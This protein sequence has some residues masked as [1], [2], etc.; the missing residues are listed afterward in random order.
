[1]IV[2]PGEQVGVEEEFAP[3]DFVYLHDGRLLASL[4]GILRVDK[5]G[6]TVSVIP[7]RER[8]LPSRGD[9]VVCTVVA[10]A[11]VRVGVLRCFAL[12]RSGKFKVIKP[13]TALL[14]VHQIGDYGISVIHEAVGIGDYVLA[15]VVSSRGPPYTIS[16]RGL[17]YG[18]IYSICP[19]CRRVLSRRGSS[20]HC[21]HCGLQVRRKVSINYLI[22]Q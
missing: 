14:P 22:G 15:K 5:R 16:T 1:V 19:N 3:L 20:L 8:L 12:S 7:I 13:V 17:S 10:H 6:H 2:T 4:V 21:S 9:D 18:V 11:S